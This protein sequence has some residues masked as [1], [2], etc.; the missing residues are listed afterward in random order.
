MR[1]KIWIWNHYATRMFENH[2]GRH[3]WFAENLLKQGY[4][5]TVFCANTFHNS[6]KL[7]D[8]LGKKYISKNSGDIPFVFVNVPKYSGNKV[9][10]IRNMAAFYKRL[11]PV[12]KQYAKDH[13]KPDVILAS[14]V[15]PLTLV[16]GIKIAK[17]FNV[18]CI[19]EVRDLWPE[20]LV[21]YGSFKRNSLFVKLLYQGEKWIYKKADKLIFTMEGG[22]D[23]ITEQG[24]DKN[25][26]GPVNINKV[27]HI[28]NGV[29]LASYDENLQNHIYTDK[30]LDNSDIFK[31]VYTG[32][33]RKANNLCLLIDAAKYVKLRGLTKVKFLIFGDGDEKENLKKKCL[34]ENIDNVLFK[35][36]VEKKFIP[37]IL[38][39]SN[40]NVLNY[41]NHAIWK[42]G[43]SQNK[44]FEY[45]ASGKPILS[46][47]TM[48]YDIIEK[49]GAGISLKKQDPET[50]G[51]TII[52]IL[53]MDV[54]L[55]EIMG[56]NARKAA[57]KF[58]FKV[59]TEKLID[60]IEVVNN[61]SDERKQEI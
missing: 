50:I 23:Y 11:F 25:H 42:Y 43:G 41:T 3:Y 49:Y 59:L 4:E 12:S 8:T 53:D 55:Y 18:P 40:L 33:I 2:G 14:S 39:K 19:C 31:V 58:D 13:G 16:A 35:G 44:N 45:L 54:H 28:N 51:K 9:S 34:D 30:I 56:K 6:D 21:S 7:I 1:K 15:H 60:L 32:S 38:S 17:K 10:R 5:P 36:R 26:G 22:K 20:S 27:H 48:G 46:T 37:N 52:S 29:D 24:W 57:E 47:I 61:E